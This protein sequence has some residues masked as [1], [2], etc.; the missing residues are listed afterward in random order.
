MLKSQFAD[1]GAFGYEL[2]SQLEDLGALGYG[3]PHVLPVAFW[4][5]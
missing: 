4:T 1:L 2:K 5:L 3:S